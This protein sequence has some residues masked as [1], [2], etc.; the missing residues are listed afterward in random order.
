MIE[1]VRILR[2]KTFRTFLLLI[3]I[4]SLLLYCAA[5]LSKMNPCDFLTRNY[6]YH[7]LIRKESASPESIEHIT[8]ELRRI[9]IKLILSNEDHAFYDIYKAMYPNVLLDPNESTAELETYEWA[10]TN[11]L[12]QKKWNSEFLQRYYKMKKEYERKVTIPIFA[13]NQELI[14]NMER[15]L[16]DYENLNG[17]TITLGDDRIITSVVDNKYNILLMAIYLIFLTSQLRVE[18]DSPMSEL[19][20]TLPR[21]RSRL[22]LIKRYA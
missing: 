19:L 15:T 6:V 18:K 4:L 2:K 9:S 1:F 16:Y 3:P 17:T 21:G 10:L 20:Y 7:D 8:D 11:I 12:E 14:E 5:Q 22:F 13:G